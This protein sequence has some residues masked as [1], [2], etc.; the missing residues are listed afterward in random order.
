MLVERFVGL[1]EGGWREVFA[2]SESHDRAIQHALALPACLGKRTVS[3]AI[4]AL[5]RGQGGDWSA[6]YKLYSRSPWDADD[7]FDPVIHT[8]LESFPSGPIVDINE[9]LNIGMFSHI[10]RAA[11][12]AVADAA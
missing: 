2:R 3:R 8:Y 9:W 1:L 6:D 11:P 10:D 12:P 5:G 7:L 4:C